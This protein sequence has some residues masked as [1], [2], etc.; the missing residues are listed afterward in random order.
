MNSFTEPEDG[1]T[2]IAFFDGISRTHLAWLTSVSSSQHLRRGEILFAKGEPVSHMYILLTGQM[3][4]AIPSER[5]QERVIDFLKP[6]DA[7]GE[8]VLLP[9]HRWITSACALTPSR[10]L[11][12]SAQ[13]L[14]EAIDRIPGFALRLI[15][16]TS[17]RCEGLIGD[18]ESASFRSAAQRVAEY[19]LRQPRTGNQARFAFH[20][21]AIASKLG[22]QPETFSRS[23]K[24]LVSDG[25]ISVQGSRITIHDED[26][27]QA[28]VD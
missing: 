26:A 24:K 7:F 1:L 10:L 28:I 16:N 9:G 19:V 15:S 6:G 11:S 5:T 8:C 12:L 13:D 14:G 27:L 3:K 20:K 2:E 23:L 4:L 21:R 25:L 22:L 17:R 18:V